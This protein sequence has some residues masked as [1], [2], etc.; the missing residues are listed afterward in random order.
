VDELRQAIRDIRA[1]TGKP[2]GVDLLLPKNVVE[3][4]GVDY[5][6]IKE[7]PLSAALKTLPKPYQDWIS[8]VRTDL[9]LPGV[10]VMVK[11]NTTTMRPLDAVKVCIEEKV[12]LFCAG[13]GNPG[14]MVN[15]GARHHGQCEECSAYGGC[16]Y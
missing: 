6:D 4:K 14:F 7:V 11:L 1:H 16:R 5:G 9:G 8:K 13:L 12:P 15:Q 10:E 2:F 3:G